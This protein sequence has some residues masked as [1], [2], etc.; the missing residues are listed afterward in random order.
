ML[1]LLCFF[2]KDFIV[3]LTIG[4]VLVNFTSA[5]GIVDAAIGGAATF[6]SCFVIWIMPV[7]LPSLFIVIGINSFLVG[8][9]LFIFIKE[10]FWISVGYV[11][12]GET[13]V[14]LV[15]YIILLIIKN[16]TKL[17]SAKKCYGDVDFRW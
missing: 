5:I 17:P 6:L 13:V 11:A 16:K 1:L 8:M 10:P 7:M 2:R 4:C 14:L 9:E 15:G 3:G 12:I